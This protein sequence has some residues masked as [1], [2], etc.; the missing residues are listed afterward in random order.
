MVGMSISISDSRQSSSLPLNEKQEE[1]REQLLER[2][3][4][5]EDFLYF[6]QNYVWIQ[7]RNTGMVVKWQSWNFLLEIA[8]AFLIHKT[9]IILK[10][11]QLGLSWLVCAYC[12]WK[13]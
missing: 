10:A 1:I 5:R 13:A 9:V 7:N 2:A 4:C 6:L 3:K 12:V 8:Q 11:R